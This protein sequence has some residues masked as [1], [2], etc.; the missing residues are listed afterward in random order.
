VTLIAFAADP[1]YWWKG[2]RR[3]QTTRPDTA[4]RYTIRGLPAGDYILAAVLALGASGPYDPALLAELAKSGVR[5]SLA[6]GERKTRD[7]K[8]VK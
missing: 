6:D 4:G 3:V 1:R 8:F 5:E 7:L 2:S